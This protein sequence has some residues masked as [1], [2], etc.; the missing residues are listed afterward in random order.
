M[1]S[2]V[3]SILAQLI[4]KPL[5]GLINN[6]IYVHNSAW[7]EIVFR[8]SQSRSYYCI[9]QAKRHKHLTSVRLRRP[10]EPLGLSHVLAALY[11]GFT[12]SFTYCK[13]SRTHLQY[14]KLKYKQCVKR[15]I[16]AF[17]YPCRCAGLCMV[18]LCAPHHNNHLYKSR[19]NSTN[20]DPIQ[21]AIKEMKSRESGTPISYSQVAKK[22]GVVC[23]GS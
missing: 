11:T 16:T 14:N 22:Y 18:E 9:T 21:E 1:Y 2:T 13:S 23:D 7:P 4:F 17:T 12:A 5:D 6:T 15:E 20:M 3:C 10:L 8:S 19:H